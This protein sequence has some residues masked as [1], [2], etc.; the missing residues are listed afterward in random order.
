MNDRIAADLPAGD[1]SRDD[2]MAILPDDLRLVRF[3]LTG[4]ELRD[5]LEHVVSGEEPIANVAGFEV[6]Y[7]PRRDEGRRIRSIRFPDGRDLRGNQTYT[8]AA[9]FNLLEGTDGFGTVQWL[10]RENVAMSDVTAL[11]QYLQRLRQPVEAPSEDRIH[12]S[13]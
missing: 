3:T 11:E 6:W 7:D 12:V 8:L 5:I 1:V 9:S 4:D 10:P 2:L 13:R